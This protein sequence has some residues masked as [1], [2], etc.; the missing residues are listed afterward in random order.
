MGALEGTLFW[1]LV[2]VFPLVMTCSTRTPRWYSILGIMSVKTETVDTSMIDVETIP[3]LK[4]MFA[5]PKTWSMA[6][7]I[8]HTTARV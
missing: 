7:T 3:N 4:M 2:C 5:P 1:V 8:T 6:N